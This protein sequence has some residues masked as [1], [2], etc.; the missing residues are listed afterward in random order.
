MPV[1]K[2]ICLPFTFDV[3]RLQQEVNIL[4][5]QQW[6]L[7]YQTKHYEGNWSA[8]PLRSINGKGDDIF[9]SPA[10]NA[11][12][13]NTAYLQSSP[14]LQEVLSA[15]K[16]PLLAVRL[17]KLDAG[18]L[19]K[20]HNDADLA[21]EKGE[22]R[23]HIPVQTNEEVEFFLD[24]ERIYV[25]EGECW[26]MNFNLPHSIHN[27]GNKDRI[28]LVIDAVANDWVKELFFQPGLLKK[29]TEEPG[30]DIDTKRKIIQ[31]LREMNTETGNRL[32]DEM[33]AALQN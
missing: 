20:E 13:E 11:V 15:F 19:I 25:K 24:K 29:E 23:I 7:H 12:Y 16:C 17:L 30:Y 22:I 18:A 3:A 14:Y 26:Y 21:F 10:E 9:I 32:A 5:L 2:Y 33:E 6:Q 1:L 4:S 28:H 8:I 31:S 27:K